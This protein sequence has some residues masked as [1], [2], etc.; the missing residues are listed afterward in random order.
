MCDLAPV[1]VCE[2][3]RADVRDEDRGERE[4]HVLETLEGLENDHGGDPHRSDGDGHP[5]WDVDELEARGDTGEFR[6]GRSHVGD[7]ERDEGRD[8]DTAAE[9]VA[10]E[11]H[12]TTARPDPHSCSELVERDQGDRG[13]REDPEELISVVGSE[14]RVGG[15][16]RRIVV[17][18]A[19]DH[20]RAGDHCE[21]RHGTTCRSASHRSSL[22]LP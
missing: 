17:G 10:D 3:A 16:S 19:C 4:E 15:D 9:A 21:G 8:R 13:E 6:A 2:E 1:G 7:D 5:G 20:V 12:E 14:D 18:E 22:Q 11:K